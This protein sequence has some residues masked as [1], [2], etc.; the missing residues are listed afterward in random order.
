MVADDVQVPQHEQERGDRGAHPLVDFRAPPV[1][2]LPPVHEDLRAVPLGFLAVDPAQVGLHR[3]GDES[4]NRR[5][6][7]PQ[8]V[9]VV[10]GLASLI[11]AGKPT[12]LLGERPLIEAG[13]FPL[14]SHQVP[15]GHTLDVEAVDGHAVRLA[16]LP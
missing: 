13:I 16:T 14:V 8:F 7:P 3:L 4:G 10:R 12:G 9:V 11:A 15:H 1:N 2:I 6:C 5:A